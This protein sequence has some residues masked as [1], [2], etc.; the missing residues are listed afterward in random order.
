[1][2]LALGV[3][4]W[5]ASLFHVYTHAFFKGCLFLCAGS[6]IHALHHEQ[7]MKNMG[8][9]KSRMPITAATY[10]IS[11]L[12]IAGIFPMSGFFSKDEILWS[13]IGQ[14][15]NGFWQFFF[16]AGLWVVGLATAGLTAF[17]MFRSYYM[18]FEGESRLSD[19]N[20]E[21]V[22][23]SPA[24]MT[25]PLMILAFG[26][27]VMGVLG[28]P[29]WL[30][31][32]PDNLTLLFKSYLAPS[33]EIQAFAA[34]S[35]GHGAFEPAHSHAAEMFFALVSLSVAG[36]GWW[37]ARKMY[38]TGGVAG[39][40]TLKTKFAGLYERAA[41]KFRVDEL[42]E[43]TWLA[44]TRKGAAFAVRADRDGIDGSI[45]GAFVRRARATATWMRGLQNGQT[46]TY[47]LGIV[48]GVNILLLIALFS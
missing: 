43:R 16:H 12:A 2:F 31:F 45:I 37:T 27:A 25:R 10:F 40:E 24:M 42:Y 26:A 9:L 30:P 14:S 21:H 34:N 23:E 4:A 15:M 17:Y 48:A 41:A 7:D 5:G 13:V 8:G 6:V 11:T 1:M 44:W 32:V 46:Q 33:I 28:M 29:G 22:H 39:D 35:V 47:A 18:A 38:R 3:G 36:L 20:E 19:H